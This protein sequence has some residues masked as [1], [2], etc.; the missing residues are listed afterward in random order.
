M[1]PR[2]AHTQIR[3]KHFLTFQTK[4]LPE[5]SSSGPTR[6]VF[7]PDIRF[8]AMEYRFLDF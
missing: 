8:R 1:P 7:T 2:L 4:A 5:L 3:P 6:I